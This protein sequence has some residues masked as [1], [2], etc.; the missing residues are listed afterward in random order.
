V[1]RW[2]TYS[3]V[4]MVVCGLSSC[5]DTGRESAFMAGFS[6]GSII[7]ANEQ[8]L[9]APHTVSG[10]TVSEPP[11]PF[12]QMHEEAIVQIDPSHVPAFMEVVR[13]SVER[14]LTSSGAKIVGRGGDH[15]ELIEQ[16]HASQGPEIRERTSDRQGQEGTPVDIAGFSFRYSDSKVDGVIYVR[17][18]RGEGTRL[19]LIVLIIES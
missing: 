5:G 1:K 17:G 4:L 8:Y 16:V 19:V 11:V 13:S 2:L 18:V 7:E 10:A 3:F 15:P 9:I 6:I 12:F 14:S